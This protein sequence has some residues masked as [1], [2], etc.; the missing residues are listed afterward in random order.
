MNR[1]FKLQFLGTAGAVFAVTPLR[2]PRRACARR[3]AA[4]RAA[5]VRQPAHVRHLP[6]QRALVSEIV[7]LDGFQLFGIAL[8]ICSAVLRR[9]P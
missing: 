3:R 2:R 7:P 1:L 5:L 4:L 8:P 9:P 6:A